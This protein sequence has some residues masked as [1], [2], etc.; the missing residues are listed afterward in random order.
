MS[1]EDIVELLLREG[2]PASVEERFSNP[3][4]CLLKARM[5]QRPYG[6][7]RTPVDDASQNYFSFRVDLATGDAVERLVRVVPPGTPHSG[8]IV[9]YWGIPTD[10]F[11]EVRRNL[12][13]LG[14]EL[15]E[16][17]RQDPDLGL[18]KEPA[19]RALFARREATFG[20]IINPPYPLTLASRRG[21][22]ALP[23]H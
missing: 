5:Y 13:Q 18:G 12:A 17:L 20:V 6:E 23:E 19:Q 22:E 7:P 15:T 21:K 3:E 1:T 11:E 8:C 9:E 2:L 4:D 14:F 10:S 16:D